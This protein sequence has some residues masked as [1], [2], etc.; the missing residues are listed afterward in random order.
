MAKYN[1]GLDLS[2]RL[3]RRNVWNT[4]YLVLS[5]CVKKNQMAKLL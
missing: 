2:L 3:Y 1:N 5:E 4:V